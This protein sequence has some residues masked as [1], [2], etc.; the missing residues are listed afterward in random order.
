M[1]GVPR[2][3]VAKNP[4][5]NAGGARDVASIPGLGRSSGVR[6][7]NSFPYSCLENSVDRRAWRAAVH[8]V[9]VSWVKLLNTA[10]RKGK[11][12]TVIMHMHQPRSGSYCQ[13]RPSENIQH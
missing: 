12:G 9:V 5:A 7:G 1:K 3:M 6:N 4:P 2:G 13:P 11:R 10:H 8:S